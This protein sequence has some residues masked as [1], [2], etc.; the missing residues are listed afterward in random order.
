MTRKENRNE[1]GS[2]RSQPCVE[3]KELVAGRESTSG[4]ATNNEA[5]KGVD[6]CLS[7]L[8]HPS[9]GRK[10]APSRAD[11]EQVVVEER[12]SELTFWQ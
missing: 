3:S 6:G 4:L 9:A 8:K 10:I 5:T 1:K 12:G 2:A 11:C 7:S